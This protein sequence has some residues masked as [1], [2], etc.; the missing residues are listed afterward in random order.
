MND[1]IVNL[2]DVRKQVK[3]TKRHLKKLKGFDLGDLLKCDIDKARVM[4][5]FVFPGHTILEVF[6]KNTGEKQLL[7]KGPKLNCII[8]T[9]NDK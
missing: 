3:A 8:T 6:Q 9:R 5:D 7:I 4:L 2:D 1:D